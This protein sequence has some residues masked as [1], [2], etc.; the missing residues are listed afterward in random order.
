MFPLLRSIAIVLINA[1]SV[2]GWYLMLSGAVWLVAYRWRRSQWSLRKIIQ[3]YPRSGQIL[4]EIGFSILSCL[5]F[6]CGSLFLWWCGQ[7]GWNQLHWDFHRYGLVWHLVCLALTFVLWDTWFYWTHRAMHSR[8]LFRLFHRTHHLSH[9]PTPFTAYSLDPLEALTYAVFLPLVCF[10]YPIHPSV[11]GA[12]MVTQFGVNL[13]IH[14]GFE[15]FPRKFAESRFKWLL[16][17]AT[18]HVMHHRYGSGNYGFCFQ[19]W[20]RLMGT[21]HPQYDAH[22]ARN[23]RGNTI[24]SVIPIEAESGMTEVH[25]PVHSSV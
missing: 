15:L 14:S 11:I 7:K 12:F 25:R 3:R 22:L 19:Y 4:R 23:C 1:A 24:A 18:S 13:V 10:I 17:S 2:L 21:C 6:G 8:M 9:N 20:D 16:S 5:I